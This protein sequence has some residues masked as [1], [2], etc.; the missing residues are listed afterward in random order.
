MQ[1]ANY[2]DNITKLATVKQA[3]ERYKISRPTLYNLAKEHNSFVKIGKCTRIDCD[4]LDK[5]LLRKWGY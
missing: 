2:T 3:M 4:T 1:K 5:A